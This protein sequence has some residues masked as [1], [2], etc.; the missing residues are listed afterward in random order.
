MFDKNRDIW[1]KTLQKSEGSMEE[2]WKE[3]IF[4]ITTDKVTVQWGLPFSFF[5]HVS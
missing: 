4:I 5:S 1:V 2:I 3:K